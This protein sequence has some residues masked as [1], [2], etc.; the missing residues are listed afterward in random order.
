MWEGFN[1]HNFCHM[2]GL[3]ELAPPPEPVKPTSNRQIP[4]FSL[5]FSTR[6]TPQKPTS[7]RHQF[8]QGFREILIQKRRKTLHHCGWRNWSDRRFNRFGG[9]GWVFFVAAGCGCSRQCASTKGERNLR[10]AN[11]QQSVGFFFETMDAELTNLIENWCIGSNYRKTWILYI[12][13][14]F[15]AISI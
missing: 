8:I 5:T 14:S 3:E 10:V 4:W 2:P 15:S 12:M 1:L 6:N 13:N 9:L 7:G 11:Y